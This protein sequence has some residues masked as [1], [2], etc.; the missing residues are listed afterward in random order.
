MRKVAWIIGASTGIGKSLAL[1]LA[2]CGYDLA[3][4]ARSQPN[5][6]LV[7][8]QMQESKECAIFPC[9]VLDV[10]SIEAAYAGVITH[11]GG[12]DLIIYAAGIYTPMPLKAFDLQKAHEILHINL[13]GAF[14]VF[15]VVKGRALSHDPLHLVWIASVAGFRGLPNSGAYGASKAGLISFSEIMRAELAPYNTKV[16]VVNPGFVKTR[17]TELNDFPMP[18]LIT[19][20]S[21]AH[22]I[23]KGINSNRFNITFPWTFGVFM[24]ILRLMPDFL[25]FKIAKRF[26]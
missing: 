16:Q 24:K 6:E 11:Y 20:E 13:G 1:L 18:M 7:R 17:L 4:S 23:L 5:L 3:I 2:R 21:A 9:D 10:N 14:N 26:L 25:Y 19:P 8:M 15:S 12:V 22:Y